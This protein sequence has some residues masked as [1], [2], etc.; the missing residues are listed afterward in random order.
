MKSKIDTTTTTPIMQSIK[1]ACKTTGLSM[2]FL[3]KGCKE[4]TIPHV[5]VGNRYRIDMPKMLEYLRSIEGGG[6]EK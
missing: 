3:R 4:G 2:Y 1:Q 5:R 6:I